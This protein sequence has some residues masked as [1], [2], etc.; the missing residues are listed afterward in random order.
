VSFGSSATRGFRGGSTRRTR[1][2]G[3]RAITTLPVRTSSWIP[4]GRSSSISASSL[5]SSPVA[6]RTNDTAVTS[7]TRARKMSAVRRISARFDGSALTRMRTSSRS[8][9]LSSVRSVTLITSMSLCSCFVT[10][11]MTNSSPRTTSVIRETDGSSVSPTDMLS[12][13]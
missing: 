1:A 10:C 8:T 3:P 11:S 6:S 9:W 2:F 13:L 5:P 7:T 4:I 12:M